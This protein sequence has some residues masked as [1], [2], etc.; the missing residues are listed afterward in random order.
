M[1]WPIQDIFESQVG[2][3]GMESKVFRHTISIFCLSE[4]L[5]SEDRRE[6]GGQQTLRQCSASARSVPCLSHKGWPQRRQ[7]HGAG[8]GAGRGRVTPPLV[9]PRSISG[10][11]HISCVE[12]TAIN[13][14][15]GWG[16]GARPGRRVL[17]SFKRTFATISQS[18]RRPLLGPSPGLALTI[19]C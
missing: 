2:G 12:M 17:Q 13:Y 3:W 19:L 11:S 4:Y 6:G 16:G 14:R 5:Q 10:P 9:L 1:M 8:A 18:Q 15:R 7:R